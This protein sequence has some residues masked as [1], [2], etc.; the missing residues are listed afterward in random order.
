[1]QFIVLERGFE[2]ARL[3]T[4]AMSD[5]PTLAATILANLPPRYEP[6]VRGPLYKLKHRYRLLSRAL[7]GSQHSTTSG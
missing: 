6:R 1:M 7:E 5:L 4:G 3:D 2:G